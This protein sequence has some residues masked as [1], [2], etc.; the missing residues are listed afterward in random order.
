MPHHGFERS[1]QAGG[2][3][4]GLYSPQSR[5]NTISCVWPSKGDADLRKQ[6]LGGQ[7]SNSVT[8]IQV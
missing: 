5:T 8:Y 4:Y 3:M 1:V 6:H 2:S 7:E